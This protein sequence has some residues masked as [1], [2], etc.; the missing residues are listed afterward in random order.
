MQT[1]MGTSALIIF[2]LGGV[3]CSSEPSEAAHVHMFS[4]ESETSS[5]RKSY[6]V[7]RTAAKAAAQWEPEASPP[8]IDVTKLIRIARDSAAIRHSQEELQLSQIDLR[9]RSNLWEDDLVFWYYEV[10]FDPAKMPDL[11]EFYHICT[12]LLPDGT[13]VEPRAGGI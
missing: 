3:A 6:Y 10:C 2:L 9:L 7:T 1:F 11:P 12:V 5:Q 4:V 8:P 13:V